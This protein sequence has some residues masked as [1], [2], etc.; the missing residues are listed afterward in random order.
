MT[1][2][3][4]NAIR[5]K[6]QRIEANKAFQRSV[7]GRCCHPADLTPEETLLLVE[8][9]KHCVSNAPDTATRIVFRKK[10]RFW[11]EVHINAVEREEPKI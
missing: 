7:I 11:Q 4:L 1:L 9:L 10:L 2:H 3:N 6:A 5:T 8:A